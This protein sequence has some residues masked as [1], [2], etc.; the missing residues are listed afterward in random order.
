[1]G[2]HSPGR[3][4]DR[5][6]KQIAVRLPEDE[7]AALDALVA[8]GRAVT[9]AAAVRAA[10]SHLIDEESRR[11]TGEA[12]A[13]GYRRIPQGDDEVEAATRAAIRSIHD[14]PW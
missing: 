13:E 10:V 7:L 8:R 12:I 1:M 5:M 9:R 4:A 3:Y 11:A 14:E 6:S 2:E